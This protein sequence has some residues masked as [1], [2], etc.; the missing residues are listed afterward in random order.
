MC[1]VWLI[2][3][4]KKHI[5]GISFRLCFFQRANPLRLPFTLILQNRHLHYLSQNRLLPYLPPHCHCPTHRVVLSVG[6]E[7][8]RH[9]ALQHLLEAHHQEHVCA[10]LRQ[11]E[12]ARP[13]QRADVLRRKKETEACYAGKKILRRVVQSVRMSSLP[14]TTCP[15]TASLSAPT[16][17]TA[18][19]HLAASPPPPF[20]HFPSAFYLPH[21][22]T[23]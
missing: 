19:L 9:V 13:A 17:H 1:F 2:L 11:V 8:V 12:H 10:R 15:H 5:L 14:V 3:Q 4:N 6:G 22:G 7:A 21:P 23:W 20:L 16:S 18:P